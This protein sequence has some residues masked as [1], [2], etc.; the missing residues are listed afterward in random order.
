MTVEVPDPVV[1]KVL[2]H[3]SRELERHQLLTPKF[4]TLTVNLIARELFRA[5]RARKET[6]TLRHSAENA[7]G[8]KTGA[9][10]SAWIEK[11]YWRRGRDSNRFAPS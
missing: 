11:S 7:R 5:K 3:R 4:G 9:A 1:R 2:G 10:G 6:G 8:A